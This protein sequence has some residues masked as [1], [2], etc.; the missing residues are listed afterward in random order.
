M[1]VGNDDPKH[2]SQVHSTLISRRLAIK[3]WLGE[4]SK[5]ELIALFAVYRPM[6]IVKLEQGINLSEDYVAVECSGYEESADSEDDCYLPKKDARFGNSPFTVHLIN[7][8]PGAIGKISNGKFGTSRGL[9][10]ED[11]YFQEGFV[12]KVLPD[13]VFFKAEGSKQVKN[14]W[15]YGHN[16]V[17]Y[18]NSYVEVCSVDKTVCGDCKCFKGRDFPVYCNYVEPNPKQ[19]FRLLRFRNW[20]I[21]IVE[22]ES[23]LFTMLDESSYDVSIPKE[24]YSWIIP[25]RLRISTPGPKGRQITVNGFSTNVIKINLN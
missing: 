20:S 25:D 6:M 2:A 4:R 15:F 16:A 23:E 13:K 10:V 3:R 14:S 7:T 12:V 9:P 24:K 17:F 8:V 1:A 11:D 21:K 22:N 5:W 18:E 19:H